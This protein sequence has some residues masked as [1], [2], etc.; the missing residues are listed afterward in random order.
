MYK[1]FFSF[2]SNL[3]VF[4]I[5]LSKLANIVQMFSLLFW[6]IWSTMACFPRWEELGCCFEK[7]KVGPL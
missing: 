1:Y 6:R 3:F 4:N 2:Y 7:D 5:I